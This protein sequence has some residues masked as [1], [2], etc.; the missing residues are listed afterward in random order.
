VWT[1]TRARPLSGAEDADEDRSLVRS[2]LT[3]RQNFA[4]D[5]PPEL[6]R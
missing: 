6:R 5:D 1:G 4:A 2:P 3:I